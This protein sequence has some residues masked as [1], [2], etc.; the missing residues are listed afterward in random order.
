MKTDKNLNEYD[1]VYRVDCLNTTMLPENVSSLKKIFEDRYNKEFKNIEMEVNVVD[2]Q[3]VNK[4]IVK[5]PF[6]Y[7]DILLMYEQNVLKFLH[8]YKIFL[9]RAIILAFA[10]LIIFSSTMNGKKRKENKYV[11]ATNWIQQFDIRY[12]WKCFQNSNS[13]R[14]L[15]FIEG[16]RVVAI[17]LVIF[18]HTHLKFLLFFIS[19]TSYIDNVI[20]NTARFL[21]IE[22]ILFFRFATTISNLCSKI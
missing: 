9:S 20:L 6:I 18:F 8:V 17:C 2:L 16:L 19:N 3:C 5:I 10:S 22:K 21:G 12:N 15:Q 7:T 13:N 11:L 1:Q 14:N 4:D